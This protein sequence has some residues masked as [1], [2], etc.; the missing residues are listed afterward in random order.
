[1]LETE[2]VGFLEVGY[3]HERESLYRLVL[4]SAS[5][6]VGASDGL[7]VATAF[8]VTSA[9]TNVLAPGRNIDVQ[10]FLFIFVRDLRFR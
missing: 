1:M 4:G 10:I 6:A 8:L 7:D 5:R 9:M 2:S 3:C